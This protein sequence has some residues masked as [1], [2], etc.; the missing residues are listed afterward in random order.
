MGARDFSSL[1][2]FG[3]RGRR[4]TAAFGGRKLPNRSGIWHGEGVT[5]ASEAR[6]PSWLDRALGILSTAPW[7]D[8]N[9]LMMKIGT[10][11]RTQQDFK[12][13]GAP[14]TQPQAEGNGQEVRHE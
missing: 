3:E 9:P 14:P 2:P 4:A 1:A 12:Q 7:R 6:A 5:N 10:Q 8:A 13:H 11:L